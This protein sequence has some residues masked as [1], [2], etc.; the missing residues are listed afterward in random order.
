VT[1]WD[2]VVRA[3]YEK[4]V[5]QRLGQAKPGCFDWFHADGSESR[6]S[7]FHDNVDRL[8]RENSGLSVARMG[9]ISLS[10]QPKFLRF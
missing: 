1:Q 6:Q 9:R 10:V 5:S 4:S 8:A 7:R 3:E 2:S